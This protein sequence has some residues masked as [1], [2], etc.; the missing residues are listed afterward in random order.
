MKRTKQLFTITLF[1]YLNIYTYY[2]NVRLV[3]R[4]IPTMPSVR[5]FNKVISRFY[6]KGPNNSRQYLPNLANKYLLYGNFEWN[7]PW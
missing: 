4:V 7:K 1:C 3:S 5:R 2:P 6:S